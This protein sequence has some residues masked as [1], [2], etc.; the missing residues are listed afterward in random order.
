MATEIAT[1]SERGKSL[2]QRASTSLTSMD[3]PKGWSVDRQITRTVLRQI[4][5]EPFFC[6]IESVA[7]LGVAIA[8][9]GRPAKDPPTLCDVIDL[10]T[11]ELQILVMNKVLLSE[12]DRAFPDNGYVGRSF[13]IVRHGHQDA[14]DTDKR[15]KLYKILELK[16]EGAVFSSAGKG[17]ID[18]TSTAAVDAAKK[19]A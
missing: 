11:G 3:P 9:S 15:Y 14:T 16:K 17:V 18:G 12:L 2:A 5:F 4:D 1:I 7:A 13:A 19:R 8:A 6:T 10:A